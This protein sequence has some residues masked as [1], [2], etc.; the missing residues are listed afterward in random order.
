MQG[1]AVVSGETIVMNKPPVIKHGRAAAAADILIVEYAETAD[2]GDGQ[3]LPPFIDDNVVWH[4][5]R[6]LPGART[7]WRRIFLKPETPRSDCRQIAS[8]ATTRK[9]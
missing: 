7:L 2:M 1:G 9:A 3:P 6:R 5:A 8:N 4:L